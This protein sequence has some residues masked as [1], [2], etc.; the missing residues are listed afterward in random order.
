M[1]VEAMRKKAKLAITP[2][3]LKKS[4]G[5]SSSIKLTPWYTRRH[6]ANADKC[7][8]HVVSYSK[9]RLHPLKKDIIGIKFKV[10]RKR[11][12]SWWRRG[13]VVFSFP[14]EDYSSTPLRNLYETWGKLCVMGPGIQAAVKEGFKFPETMVCEPGIQFGTSLKNAA[15]SFPKLKIEIDC[16][17]SS[18]RRLEVLRDELVSSLEK[19]AKRILACTGYDASKL[20]PVDI[21]FITKEEIDKMNRK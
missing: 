4:K 8:C 1:D 3:M 12:R 2:A 19:E 15:G 16:L 6:M 11:T 20:T 5:V 14:A 18:K 13:P 21:S 10:H 9:P 7:S 17:P